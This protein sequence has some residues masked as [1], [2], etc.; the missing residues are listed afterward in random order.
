MKNVELASWVDR[1]AAART[2]EELVAI[3]G[4]LTSV[5]LTPERRMLQR[6]IGEFI[7]RRERR[8][9]ALDETPDEE[10][11]NGPKLHQP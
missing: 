8:A 5:P 2:T 1:I 10:W 11:G 3:A 6:T 7:S 4:E 9:K